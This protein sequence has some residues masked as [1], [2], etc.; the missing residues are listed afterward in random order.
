MLPLGHLLSRSQKFS[1]F[2]SEPLCPLY[3]ILLNKETAAKHQPSSMSRGCG[4]RL[5]VSRPSSGGAA[6]MHLVSCCYP[7]P[8]PLSYFGLLCRTCTILLYFCHCRKSGGNQP[9]GVGGLWTDTGSRRK[10]MLFTL[11]LFQVVAASVTLC[12]TEELAGAVSL[13]STPSLL[14]L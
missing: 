9:K 7:E 14:L 2:R 6:S 13:L 4:N 1:F 8:P 11:L 5:A 10:P 12:L 3:S